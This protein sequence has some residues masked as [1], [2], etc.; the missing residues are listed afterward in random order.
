MALIY[1]A[2]F[3]L[4]QAAKKNY[5]TVFKIDIL[6]VD[7]VDTAQMAHTKMPRPHPYNLVYHKRRI[8]ILS[9]EVFEN[10]CAWNVNLY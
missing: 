7:G 10:R 6:W 4:I 8:N 1:F 2:I 3:S 5:V 9:G